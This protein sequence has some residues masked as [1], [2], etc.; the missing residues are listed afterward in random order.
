MK[1]YK[2]EIS[3]AQSGWI[4]KVISNEVEKIYPLHYA[5]EYLSRIEPEEFYEGRRGTFV[6]NSESLQVE[7]RTSKMDWMRLIDWESGYHVNWEEELQ[8]CLKSPYYFATAYMKVNG[9]GF[10]THLTE[11]SFNRAFSMF[12]S[13]PDE[14]VINSV[15]EFEDCEIPAFHDEFLYS[16]IEDLVIMWA[17]DGKKTAGALTRRI[18]KLIHERSV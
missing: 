12:T 1:K 15:P 13:G 16:G 11:D 18:M 8:R 17:N 4:V 2:G 7:G 9:K 3:K 5:D 14:S 10:T 6:L